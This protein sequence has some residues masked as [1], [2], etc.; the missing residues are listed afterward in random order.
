MTVWQCLAEFPP[1]MV[2]LAARRPLTSTSCASLSYAE[3]AIASALPI[4]RVVEISHLFSWDTVTI[5]ELRRF[6]AACYFDPSSHRDR[7]RQYDILRKCKKQPNQPPRYL[8]R[9]PYWRSEILPLIE[10]LR[11]MPQTLKSSDDF[12]TSPSH[13]AS[14]AA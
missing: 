6:C 11:T 12:A 8:R 3:I 2:R 10:H 4:A 7:D 13:Q 14:C 1:V 5:G 9:S